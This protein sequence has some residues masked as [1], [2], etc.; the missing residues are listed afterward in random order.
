M[1][2][3]IKDMEMP[4]FGYVCLKVL[5]NGEVFMTKMKRGALVVRG[6]C[7]RV[8]TAVPVPPHGELCDKASE[9]IDK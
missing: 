1:G 3:Y 4:D 5:A 8:G 2:I 7:D 6:I 9:A